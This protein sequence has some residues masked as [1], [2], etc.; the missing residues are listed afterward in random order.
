MQNVQVPGP[1][2]MGGP[3]SIMFKGVPR[4]EQE[5]DLGKQDILVLI[6]T[7]CS[8]MILRRIHQLFWLLFEN[9]FLMTVFEVRVPRDWFAGDV[10]SSFH[11]YG[12]YITGTKCCAEE[13]WVHP[14]K[15]GFVWCTIFKFPLMGEW[16]YRMKG[17]KAYNMCSYTQQQPLRSFEVNCSENEFCTFPT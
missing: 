4:I 1:E 3:S 12:W 17:K 9:E 15:Y 13:T 2:W 6:F 16:G 10:C 8:N 11:V 14:M 7:K 5:C